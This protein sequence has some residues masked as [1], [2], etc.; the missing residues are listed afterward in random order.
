MSSYLEQ[1]ETMDSGKREAV[2]AAMLDTMYAIVEQLSGFADNHPVIVDDADRHDTPNSGSSAWNRLMCLKWLAEGAEIIDLQ[3]MEN[4]KYVLPGSNGHDY[5]VTILNRYVFED[6]LLSLQKIQA[7]SNNYDGVGKDI[8]NAALPNL[9]YYDTDSG[10]GLVNGQKVFLQDRNKR[11]FN[12][13]FKATP[14]FVSRNALL[15]IARSRQYK[16]DPSMYVVSEAFNL[17]R[18]A[19][20]VDSTVIEVDKENGSA[21]LNAKSFPLSFQL[22]QNSYSKTNIRPK[23]PPK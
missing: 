9:A 21:R 11:L 4:S 14:K 19:C 18:K 16:D 23:S 17:L 7:R 13:L 10:R 22:F 20:K 6:L 3:Y 1:L 15:K 5:R 2:C 12:E 8:E